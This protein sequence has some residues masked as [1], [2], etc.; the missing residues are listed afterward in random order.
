[1]NRKPG[2]GENGDT[3]LGQVFDV[4]GDTATVTGWMEGIR[5]A[6]DV[7]FATVVTDGEQIIEGSRSLISLPKPERLNDPGTGRVE[8]PNDAYAARFEVEVPVSETDVSEVRVFAFA[9]PFC[10]KNAIANYHASN[11]VFVQSSDM[12]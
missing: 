5:G 11:S 7:P 9:N 3:D 10:R 1:M 12:Q 4:A 2:T 6:A 8:V